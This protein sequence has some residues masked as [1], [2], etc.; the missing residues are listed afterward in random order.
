[1]NSTTDY[2][3]KT[4]TANMN[5]T[6]STFSRTNDIYQHLND[7]IAV[8]RPREQNEKLNWRNIQKFPAP[9]PGYEIP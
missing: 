7:R 9:R 8:F 2:Y 3:P 4:M 6:N 5:R 1:M